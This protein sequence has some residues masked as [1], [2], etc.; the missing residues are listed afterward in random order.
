MSSAKTRIR[1]APR[2]GGKSQS[3][4]ANPQSAIGLVVAGLLVTVAVYI[5]HCIY[6]WAY[7]NDD[8]YITFRYSRF[9]AMGRGPYFNIGEQVEGYTNFLLMLLVTPIIALFGESN[10]APFAK[11]LGIAGGALAI[12]AIGALVWRIGRATADSPLRSGVAAILAAALVA[13]FPAYALNST[14]GLETMLLAGEISLGLLLGHLFME[15]G[16]WRGAGIAFACA[17]LTRPEGILFFAIYWLAQLVAQRPALRSF[18][19][20][21]SPFRIHLFDALIV[22]VVFAAHLVF[23]LIAYDGE[24]LPN[25]YYAK[26]GGF[27]K[28]AAASY[29]GHGA[30]RPF[31]DIYGIGAGIGVV[32]WILSGAT[33]RASLP[34][35]CIAAAGAL[36]PFVTGTDWMLGWRLLMP[37]LPVIAGV[38][39]IGW[40]R[41]ATLLVRHPRWLGPPLVLLAVPLL[42]YLR[43]DDRAFFHDHIAMRARGYKTGHT[44]LAQ[45]LRSGA[46][47]KGDTVA[48]MDIGIVGYLCVD[49][50]IL[51]ITG[52][53]DRTIAKS[54]GEFM[55]KEYDTRYVLGRKP[56]FIVLVFGAPG[57][58]DVPAPLG[59]R[60]KP[61]STND[62]RIWNDPDFRARYV[63]PRPVSPRAAYWT[64][65]VA[66][67]LGAERVFEHAHPGRYYLLAAF[68]RSD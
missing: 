17:A 52:L 23:R 31:F 58:P 9:L 36:L 38:V 1:S 24:W 57:N 49:Q 63:R 68:R 27:W 43:S 29:I 5:A 14:S 19:I 16:R 40:C 32:G 62:T 66:A 2:N 33:R 37:F 21:N 50:T 26:A 60:L 56:E 53:T 44:A 15:S 45:W 55:R 7:V 20:P 51:D 10:A 25:T 18:R 13:V 47:K 3:A 59:T 64:D 39:A 12:G 61:W 48:L 41:I 8:A 30:L 46:A 4:I 11:G 22:T 42:W 35:F 6:F 65:N 28:V 67:Q 54:T 34:L